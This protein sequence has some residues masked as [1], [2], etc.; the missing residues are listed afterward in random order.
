MDRETA[1]QE[2]KARIP[3]T[4]YL[5]KSKGANMYVCPFCNSGSNGHNN[6]GAMKYYPE[7]N[8]CY[9]HAC[10][11][12][13]DSIELYQHETGA[14]FSTA[15]ISLAQDIGI[16]IEPYRSTAA[17]DF[18]PAHNTQKQAREAHSMAAYKDNA[19]QD[20]TAQA[21]AGTPTAA[22][23]REYYS[24]CMS[25][26]NDPAAVS[27]LKARGINPETAYMYGVG[28]DPTADPASAPAA[29]T[30]ANKMHPAPRIIIPI[31][32]DYYIGRAIN[33]SD[34]R[35]INPTRSKGAGAAGIF[36]SRALY[37]Q[38]VQEIFITEGAINAL[39]LIEAGATAIATNSTSNADILLKALEERPTAA[40]L[41]LAFDADKAGTAATEKMKAGLKRLNIPYIIASAD[42]RGTA[43]ADGKKKTDANDLLINNRAAFIEAVAQAQRMTAARP[44][45][46]S[47]Y[48]DNLMSGDIDRFKSEIKTGFT[49]LDKKAGG[50]YAGLY[51]IAAI[52]SLG[53]TTFTAQMADQIAAAGTDVLFFSM[54]QS[55]LE[56]VSKSIARKTFINDR[57]KAV[58]SL[59]IRKGYLPQEVRTAAAQYKQE[60][61][62][63]ISI[64]EGNF[65]CDISF[66]GEYVRQYIRKNNTRPVIMVDY[67]QVLQPEQQNGRQ[68]TTKET[69]DT[70]ITELKRISREMDLPIFVISSVNRANY[71]TPI[72][73]ESLKESG[74]IE[75]TAD[76]IW[77]LQLQ[78]LND[79]IFDK[80]NNI[81]ERREKVKEAKA[82]M[83]RKIELVC[84]KN[85]Y[86]IANFSS[87]FNYYPAND[88]F[89]ESIG[90]D[91]DFMPIG[92]GRK[93]G[94]KL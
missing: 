85:R 59:S 55:R 17:D 61:Q 56:M 73:F 7:T 28:F 49:D 64:I 5:Q 89:E 81:K 62:E 26:I 70:S 29:M 90:A 22:D 86:G 32:K 35:Y 76:V 91:V 2:I 77:G 75:Y 53:K 11:R 31:T 43:D 66:I 39:S 68:Q 23:Y 10:G 6:T 54:E 46:I 40:T 94:R 12:K 13:A 79:P 47:Y 24:S 14:D 33:S 15:L 82:A 36:N 16:D 18:K 27:F 60:V 30:D 92:N 9:C 80:A 78:C 4:D 48:I 69:I 1:K 50:I 34:P 37:A 41:V 52:S 72:D 83:P 51:V 45:N 20:K 8:T 87:Y 19:P 93:A 42:I 38:E 71:L 84:L 57:E 44:D 67:L 3:C 25:R 63:H 74:S 58:S 88:Y 65:N 21:A